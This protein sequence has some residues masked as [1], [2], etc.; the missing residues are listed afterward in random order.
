[1]VATSK[2]KQTTYAAAA[3]EQKEG[4]NTQE[5]HYNQRNLK[6]GRST[7]YIEN[8]EEDE[9]QNGY[10][11]AWHGD[12]ANQWDDASQQ[13]FSNYEM[14]EQ[15]KHDQQ[16]KERVIQS[17]GIPQMIEA[18]I[19]AATNRIT[20]MEKQMGD[21]VRETKEWKGHLD[22]VSEQSK[23]IEDM[24][25]QIQLQSIQMQQNT[26][27]TQATFDKQMAMFEEIKK[28]VK[29]AGTQ[30]NEDEKTRGGAK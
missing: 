29:P 19:A 16:F 2:G 23:R 5:A 11:T 21:I 9:S 30:S 4:T 25:A 7:I 1:M 17:M 12:E 18:S 6:R 28:Y 14:L 13:K 8:E 22:K 20:T 27:E 26:N 10:E 24:Q 15:M 3:R